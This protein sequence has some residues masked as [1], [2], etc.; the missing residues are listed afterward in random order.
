MSHG[1]G[2]M[3]YVPEPQPGWFAV[4]AADGPSLVY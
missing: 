4:G 1:N 3:L 2:Y